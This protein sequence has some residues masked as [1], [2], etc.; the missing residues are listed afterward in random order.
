MLRISAENPKTQRKELDY[1][2]NDATR[3]LLMREKHIS[4]QSYGF[5]WQGLN[6]KG[7]APYW[8]VSA[9]TLRKLFM[10][11]IVMMFQDSN[12]NIQMVIAL[13]GLFVF[14]ASHIRVKP[15]DSFVHDKLEIISLFVSQAT[16]FTG[17]IANFIKEDQKSDRKNLSEVDAE[18]INFVL[19]AVIV[20]CNFVFMFYFGI[21][22]M[23]HAFFMLDESV[24]AVLNKVCGCCSKKKTKKRKSITRATS[25]I[26]RKINSKIFDMNYTYHS[27]EQKEA[28]EM[29]NNIE[30]RIQQVIEFVVPPGSGPGKKIILKGANN[31]RFAVTVP[32]YAHPGTCLTFTLNPTDGGK[33]VR[34]SIVGTSDLSQSLGSIDISE[35]SEDAYQYDDDDQSSGGAS[36]D[37]ALHLVI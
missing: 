34:R 37:E 27:K 1:V 5:L 24:Q 31:E 26:V 8:E 12:K 15:Y 9:V 25:K 11:F 10:I 33:H 22:L 21:N 19:G 3:I 35:D 28:V 17:L 16:M 6:E 36:D 20:F 14:T 18:N 32:D 7:H 23:Y 4:H 30:Q 29:T 13:M 2:E